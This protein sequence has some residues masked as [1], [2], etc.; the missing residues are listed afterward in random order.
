L[1]APLQE[2]LNTYCETTA[3][4]PLAPV[5]RMVQ[6]L[7]STS[8]RG[9]FHRA[10]GQTGAWIRHDPAFGIAA[11]IVRRNAIQTTFRGPRLYDAPYDF[12][13]ETA[14]R[15]PVG[16]V[17]RPKN[18]AGRD[19]SRGQPVVD[20]KLDPC[21]DWRRSNVTTL[22][23]KIGDDPVLFS[24]LEVFDG[25]PRYLRPPEAATEQNRDRCVV[26]FGT[27]VLTAERYEESLPWSAVNQFP[28]RMP[29]FFTPLTRRIPAAR[30]G[31]RSPQPAASYA[32]RRI[33]ARRR[34]IVDKAVDKF[35]N[36]MIV[37]PLRAASARHCEAARR[38]QSTLARLSGRIG[39]HH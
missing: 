39:Y 26:A 22:A 20:R 35:T 27:Q 23:S 9:P 13:T 5:G 2:R 37:G 19:A 21:R 29:C 28:M 34:L 25:E 1:I 6:V 17:N 15:D 18:R 12:R 14:C 10:P 4:E 24:L 8:I 33:A 3:G 16:L 38:V 30:S 36:R 32:N 7:I 31:L 11:E